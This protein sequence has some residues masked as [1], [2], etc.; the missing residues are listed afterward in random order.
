M[1]KRILWESS[2]SH[3]EPAN[4]YI[5][6]YDLGEIVGKLSFASAAY[7]LI[8]GDLPTPGQSRM[9]EAVMCSI[10]DYAL[11][12][13]GTVAARINVSGN[14]SMTAGLATA[15]LGA[16]EY[17]LAPEAGGAFLLNSFRDYK[18]SG[19]PMAQAAQALVARLRERGERVPGFGHPVFR[20]TDPRAQKLKL[21]AQDT[22]VWGETCEWYEAIHASFT[23]AAGK[24]DLVIN[25][26]GMLSAI[27][28]QM[29][30]SPAEMTGLAVTSTI[31]GVIAH[32]SEEIRG[33]VRIRGIPD[34][35]VTYDRTTR[36]LGEGLA[37][38]GWGAAT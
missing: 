35:D 37:R 19:L 20:V 9:M 13:P 11:G 21:I 15:V 33:K 6:G 34:E 16:G 29:G 2:V 23:K 10:L 28:A 31:P 14:P 27:L 1:S 36:D 30:F 7:L 25:D 18:D 26:V 12:K 32:V 4:V 22:G 17:T 5:R 24:P 3:V 38:A 8:R